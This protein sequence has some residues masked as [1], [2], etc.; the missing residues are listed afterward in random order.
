MSP[1]PPGDGSGG[2]SRRFDGHFAPA[3]TNGAVRNNELREALELRDLPL[4]A[5]DSGGVRAV[6]DGLLQID[7]VL[8]FLVRAHLTGKAEN[9]ILK[10]GEG[11]RDLAVRLV[12]ASPVG[13][14]HVL[15]R[16]G[17]G[18]VEL[19]AGDVGVV[20]ALLARHARGETGDSGS[21]HAVSAETA[22]EIAET[23]VEQPSRRT[24][25]A[26][27]E[28][29]PARSFGCVFHDDSSLKISP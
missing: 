23:A 16:D 19:I 11:V 6:V 9:A 13:D 28:G 15:L 14:L 8:L 2:R 7:A 10:L 20:S 26:E 4:D 1:P 18:L 27:T 25:D 12:L 24:G 21:Y 17:L 5:A 22:E 3:G 29:R